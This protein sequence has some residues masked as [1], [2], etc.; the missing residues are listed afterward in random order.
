[1]LAGIGVLFSLYA[2]FSP[3]VRENAIQMTCSSRLSQLAYG[4]QCYQQN[5]GCCPPAWITD[6][7]G[8]PRYSWRLLILP[9]MEGADVYRSYNY[10]LGWDAPDN[11][12][13]MEQMAGRP[14]G[15][16]FRCPSD[17]SSASETSYLALLGPERL[18]PSRRQPANLKV[19]SA[20]LVVEVHNSEIQ[21][22]EPRDLVVG[23]ASYPHLTNKT[24]SSATQVHPN[25]IHWFRID[26]ATRHSNTSQPS[27]R[28]WDELLKSQDEY[29]PSSDEEMRAFVRKLCTLCTLSRHDQVFDQ[30]GALLLLGQ[31]GHLATDALPLMREFTTQK[32][33]TMIK[34]VAILG[35]KKIKRSIE[36][37]QHRRMPN[38][39]PAPVGGKN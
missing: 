8:N 16:L 35:I 1:M 23:Q 12:R 13:L 31:L 7:F 18:W 38:K 25:A 4:F 32:N 28:S 6:E 2:A 26:L 30:H 10:S 22:F 27:L 15:Q 36:I 11:I 39:P 5:F 9:Y 21:Y 29:G 20:Q 3:Y 19:P 24:A 33:P 14:G 17:T 37:E 34:Q